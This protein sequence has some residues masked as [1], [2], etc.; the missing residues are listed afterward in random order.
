MA[1]QSIVCVGVS[2]DLHERKGQIDI[3]D[4]LFVASL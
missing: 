2:I 3:V 1:S 4:W